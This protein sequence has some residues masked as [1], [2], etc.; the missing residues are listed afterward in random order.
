MFKVCA[1][2]YQRKV[3]GQIQTLRLLGHGCYQPTFPGPAKRRLSVHKLTPWI[4]VPC[5]PSPEIGTPDA[6]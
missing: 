4:E 2:K 5:K 3:A 6:K 1:K